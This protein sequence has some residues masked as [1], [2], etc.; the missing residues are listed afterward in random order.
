MMQTVE[1]YIHQAFEFDKAICAIATCKPG[2]QE[3][4]DP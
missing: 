1:E 4:D 3:L 2:L